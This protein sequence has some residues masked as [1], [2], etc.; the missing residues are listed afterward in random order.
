MHSIGVWLT[1]VKQSI[2]AIRPFQLFGEVAKAA[3]MLLDVDHIDDNRIA[4]S[5]R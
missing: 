5:G 1:G 2:A 3:P 4:Q